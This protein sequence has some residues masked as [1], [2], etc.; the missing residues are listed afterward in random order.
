[1][2]V[3][4]ILFGIGA[5]ICFA[6]SSALEQHAAKQERPTRTL[7]PRL[8]TRLLRRPMWLFGS[9]PDVAGTVL[10][11]LALRAGP[12]A[13]V[14]PL[15]MSGLFMAIPLEAALE[16]RRPHKR[17]LLVVAVGA[18]GL[19]AFLIAADPKAGVS[20][21]SL[22]AW[23]AVVIVVGALVGIC[24]ALAWRVRGARRGT[25]L[26][27]ATGLLYALAAGLLKDVAT[28]VTVDPLSLFADWHLYALLVVGISAFI[29]N[30]NALQAGPIAAPLTAITLLDP[31]GGV[32]IG[33]VAFKEQLSFDGIRLPIEIVAVVVMVIGIWLTTTTRSK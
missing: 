7:D 22:T 26:G 9:V 21:P 16:R 29:L 32:I 6:L 24:L 4:A 19:T 30:Q 12:L 10:Q 31:F 14:E 23:L 33:V 2:N 25:L 18:V 20:S 11:A 15:L 8:L 13:L 27:I 1:M 5:A 3:A 17:D 28:K